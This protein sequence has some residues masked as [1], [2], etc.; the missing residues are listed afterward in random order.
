MDQLAA[1]V[2]AAGGVMVAATV[3]AAAMA[4]AVVE[5]DAL[6]EVVVSPTAPGA[7]RRAP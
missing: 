1:E 7:H 5:R 6:A 4:E 3:A 2:E